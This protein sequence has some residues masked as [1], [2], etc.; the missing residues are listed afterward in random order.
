MKVIKP[1]FSI[2]SFPNPTVQYTLLESVIVSDRTV[3]IANRPFAMEKLPI[4][5]RLIYLTD[6]SSSEST[7]VN[8]ITG[9]LSVYF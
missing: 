1:V 2:V 4:L 7:T 9:F 6:S 3:F 5:E 8:G